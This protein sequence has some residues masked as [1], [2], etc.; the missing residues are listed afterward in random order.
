MS[1]APCMYSVAEVME[2][3][4]ETEDQVLSRGID[5]PYVFLVVVPELGACEVPAVALW[6]FMA[7]ADEY[8]ATCMFEH[9][10]KEP[11]GPWVIKRSQLRIHADGVDRLSIN[12]ACAMNGHAP[13]YLPGGGVLRER[14]AAERA[15]GP[16]GAIEAEAGPVGAI[17]AEAGPVVPG[18]PAGGRNPALWK[19]KART[20]AREFVK[21]QKARDLFPNQDDIACEIEKRF[22]AE[23]IMGAIGKPLSAETI[24]RR[25]L[26]GISSKVV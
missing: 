21:Q 2:Q 19:E 20:M 23:G 16:V 11:S 18:V 7:G 13:L 1:T 15:A 22:R 6:H 9:W 3:G 12:L 17:E 24:K 26:T 14:L 10:S 8:A 25:A 4:G 5:G